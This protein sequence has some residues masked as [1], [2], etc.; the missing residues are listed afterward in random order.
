MQSVSQIASDMEV[1]KLDEMKV[2]GKEKK[3]EEV[4]KVPERKVEL[5]DLADLP[6]K[7]KEDEKKLAPK[8][9]EREVDLLLLKELMA[10]EKPLYPA[11][12]FPDRFVS[13]QA[14]IDK[15]RTIRE[16]KFSAQDLMEDVTDNQEIQDAGLNSIMHLL[17]DERSRNAF[18]TWA[19]TDQRMKELKAS[20]HDSISKS[21]E[22]VMKEKK[23][24]KRKEKEKEKIGDKL[25]SK[26]SR[27][28]PRSKRTSKQV[29]TIRKAGK[30]VE[31][32][33][34]SLI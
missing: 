9:G 29:T 20:S 1:E 15:G 4:E 21:Q 23:E 8:S 25:G 18:L 26:F 14:V 5:L 11:V 3:T 19:V 17:G 27:R 30:D 7:E 6:K 24:E 28:P 33:R 32:T 22:K 12:H 16:N 13:S 34:L 2:E 10:A 31:A